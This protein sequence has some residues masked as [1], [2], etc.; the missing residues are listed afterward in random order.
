MHSQIVYTEVMLEDTL[1]SYWTRDHGTFSV[2][3]MCMNR[4]KY[5]IGYRFGWCLYLTVNNTNPLYPQ[6]A[7]EDDSNSYACTSELVLAHMHGGVTFREVSPE[8]VQIGCD[9]SHYVDEEY[10]NTPPEDISCKVHLFADSLESF[11]MEASGEGMPLQPEDWVKLATTN[12]ELKDLYAS[13]LK[14][15]HPFKPTVVFL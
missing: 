5:P 7:I 11:V 8:T 13:L 10:R 12:W 1:V 14:G 2:Q 6:V 9:F 4:P 3:V 15:E